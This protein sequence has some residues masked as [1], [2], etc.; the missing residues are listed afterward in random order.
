MNRDACP[1]CPWK[2]DRHSNH[3]P[4]EHTHSIRNHLQNTHPS[5]SLHRLAP[6]FFNKHNLH[7]CRHCNTPTILY[8]TT[9]ALKAHHIHAHTQAHTS[10]N[11]AIISDTLRHTSPDTWSRNLHWLFHLQIKPPSFTGNLWRRLGPKTQH[12]LFATLNHIHKWILLASMPMD[13]PHDFPEYQT[14]A[15]PLWKLA[16]LFDALI[17]HPTT[18][19]DPHPDATVLLRLSAFRRGDIQSLH[20]QASI[21]HSTPIQHRSTHFRQRR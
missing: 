2:A 20:E 4:S 18:P 3:S 11:S 9:A 16:I 14:S 10:I 13:R 21:R 19:T 5:Q 12:E 1:F 8:L 7:P 6:D 17:L 15:K